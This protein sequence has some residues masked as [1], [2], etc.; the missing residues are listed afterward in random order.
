LEKAGIYSD[1]TAK[2][3][4]FENRVS[5]QTEAK[6]HADL[7]QE[8]E[9]LVQTIH[10]LSGF[11]DFLGPS[12]YSQLHSSIPSGGFVVLLNF[13][14]SIVPL[15]QHS[16]SNAVILSRDAD[17]PMVVRFRHDLYTIMQSLLPALQNELVAQEFLPE[18]LRGEQDLP[19]PDFNPSRALG[20]F[21]AVSGRPKSQGISKL[22]E[23]LWH[24]I[25]QPVVQAIGLEVGDIF[26]FRKRYLRGAP[27][28]TALGLAHR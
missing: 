27:F 20:R 13:H 1:S 22:L 24:S 19:D 25:C 5:L 8:W 9:E 3:E 26:H 28:S 17:Q 21:H 10:S 18:L 2:L 14:D 16:M 6:R 12:P 7:A 4:S 15:P 23:F 11:K